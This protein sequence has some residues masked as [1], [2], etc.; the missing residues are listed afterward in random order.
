[1]SHWFFM[2]QAHRIASPAE[3]NARGATLA[4]AFWRNENA[5]TAIEYALMGTL[6]AVAI[7]GICT[8]MFSK[9]SAEYGEISG[10]F[11]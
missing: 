4:K 7:V 10:A 3:R 9:L 8:Q 2:R 11:S 1:M 6:I 5:S